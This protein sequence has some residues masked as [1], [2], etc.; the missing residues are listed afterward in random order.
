MTISH[1]NIPLK[2]LAVTLIGLGTALS[3]NASGFEE[4][5]DVT[6]EFSRSQPVQEIY[7]EFQDVAEREC[8]PRNWISRIRP[9]ARAIAQCKADLV[10]RV[11]AK[12]DFPALTAY[13]RNQIELAQGSEKSSES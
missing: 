13:H 3:A 11:I 1:F 12:S 2:T 4:K 7:A 5:F 6:F 8:Q 9:P 10:A